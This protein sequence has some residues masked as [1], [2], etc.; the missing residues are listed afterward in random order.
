MLA[1]INSLRPNHPFFEKFDGNKR[2]NISC[3]KNI[4]VNWESKYNRLTISFG[5]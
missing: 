4:W 3:K 2:L 5:K 1:F